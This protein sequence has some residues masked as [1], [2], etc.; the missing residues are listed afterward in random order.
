MMGLGDV[1][2]QRDPEAGPGEPGR[3]ADSIVSRYFT[4]RRCHASHA[5]TGA[6]G[7]ATAFALPATVAS[8]R[9]APPGNHDL[10]I[11]HPAG[12]IDV[13]VEVEGEGDSASITSAALVRTA[14]KIFQG[15]LHLPDYVFSAPCQARSAD[16]RDRADLAP[17]VATTPSHGS[18]RRGSDRSSAARSGSTI[19]PAQTARLPAS[20]SPVPRPTAA[21]LL[22]YVATHAMSP[23]LQPLGYD[24]VG[25]FEPVGLVGWSPTLL[26]P[27]HPQAAA[28]G[29]AGL[30]QR[31]R[32]RPGPLHLCVGRRRHGPSFRCRTVQAV[33]RNRA[34]RSVYVPGLVPGGERHRPP[35]PRRS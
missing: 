19:A 6:I 25:D 22:G 9:R 8:G 7:V 3:R 31:I 12:Q 30:L 10:V 2:G 29:L 21:P 17:A 11:Q 20:S 16:D 35:P 15:E 27:A 13:A 23:A 1:A 34:A 5:V 18:S 32:A 33:H 28:A 24:P 4:P 14:R 26:V